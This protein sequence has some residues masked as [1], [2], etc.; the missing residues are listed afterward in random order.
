M[1]ETKSAAR[2]ILRHFFLSFLAYAGLTWFACLSVFYTSLGMVNWRSTENEA[3][4]SGELTGLLILFLIPMLIGLYLLFRQL[5]K[6]FKEKSPFSSYLF[7]ILTALA[8]LG[9]GFFLSCYQ[10]TCQF[11]FTFY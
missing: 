2:P 10:V 1:P 3:L 5:V 9:A 11:G 7:S 4:N 6:L 8:G